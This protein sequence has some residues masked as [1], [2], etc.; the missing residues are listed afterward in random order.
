MRKQAL[1]AHLVKQQEAVAPQ[2]CLDVAQRPTDVARRV[3]HIGCNHKVIDSRIDALFGNGL[4]DIEDAAPQI[5]MINPI[6]A[7]CVQQERLRQI[8]VTILRDMQGK[9]LQS[10]QHSCAGA[11]SAGSHFEYTNARRWILLDPRL[12]EAGDQPSQRCVE[13]V[14]NPVV[15]INSF[16]KSQRATGKHHIGCPPSSAEKVG[17]RL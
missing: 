7:P 8:R 5:R 4:L 10:R 14:R 15:L 17:Q 11:S 3:Q 12:D 2:R 13:V 6:G 16:H 1:C 9:R